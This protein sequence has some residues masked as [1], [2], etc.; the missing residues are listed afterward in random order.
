MR[1]ENNMELDETDYFMEAIVEEYEDDIA[2][3]KSTVSVD[4]IVARA[5]FLELSKKLIG[6]H[7]ATL[8]NDY[9]KKMTL[10]YPELKITPS[11]ELNAMLANVDLRNES[12][13]IDENYAQFITADLIKRKPLDTITTPIEKVHK[14]EPSS[15]KDK[16]LFQSLSKAI[17][18]ETK[19]SKRDSIFER[20]KDG[21]SNS[22][23][24]ALLSVKKESLNKLN[25]GQPAIDFEAYDSAGRNYNLSGFIG[26]YVIVDTWASWCG[27]CK[28]Q[29]PF[30]IRKYNKYKKENIVF[31]SINVDVKKNKW[32]ED[33]VEM[34]KDILQLRAQDIDGF[35][36]SYA[37]NSIPRFLLFDKDGT[38]LVSDFTYP[39]D[40]SFDELLDLKL[41]L[42]RKQ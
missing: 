17:E 19:N 3:L 31:I 37:I 29:E 8:W 18:E 4:H 10:Y 15:F 25:S 38:I 42:K 24:V 2:D 12:L 35:M 41:G 14:I 33:L 40:K 36:N 23:Y 7:Y 39:S 27:P 5:D 26:S 11:K 13:L 28:F 16:W 22:R 21:F 20:F 6:V 32:R 34:N 9:I 1:I 30:Y